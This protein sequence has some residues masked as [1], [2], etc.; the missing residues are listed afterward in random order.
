MIVIR[1]PT[2]H[3]GV[4]PSNATPTWAEDHVVRQR[5]EGAHG[6]LT[7]KSGP[8]DRAFVTP[9]EC[10]T[11][12]VCD[13]LEHL[14]VCICVE[15]DKSLY[16]Y[17]PCTRTLE[18]IQDHTTMYCPSVLIRLDIAIRDLDM[19]HANTAV[20]VPLYSLHELLD[21]HLDSW[22]TCAVRCCRIHGLCK[23]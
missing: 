22:C 21:Q 1:L 5:T 16:P 13:T 2:S 19:A 7:L 8:F 18:P 10:Y 14:P 11:A 17:L 20:L 6:P 23:S 4:M 15:I 9:V 3:S 12:C